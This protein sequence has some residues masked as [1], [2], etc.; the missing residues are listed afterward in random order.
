MRLGSRTLILVGLSA[1]LLLPAATAKEVPR[2]GGDLGGLV[3]T[4]DR[5][6]GVAKPQQVLVF[7]I[8]LEAAD[9]VARR[10]TFDVV[11]S[12][13]GF[14]ATPPAPVTLPSPQG[15]EAVIPFMVLVSYHNGYVDEQGQ[16]VLRVTSTPTDGGQ[17]SALDVTFNVASRGMY[18]PSPGAALLAPLVAAV[19]VA[20]SASRT[21]P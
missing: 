13:P 8:R 10:V 9:G 2:P 20:L 16:V 1:L 19:A 21:R 5:T 11:G 14:M 15:D 17:A 3:L 7:E 18:V 4:V 6:E 12:P